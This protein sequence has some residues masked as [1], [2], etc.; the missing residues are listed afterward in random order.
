[1]AIF[2]KKKEKEKGVAGSKDGNEG[3]PILDQQGGSASGSAS[4]HN[5]PSAAPPLGSG[6]A[7]GQPSSMRGPPSNGSLS[8]HGPKSSLGQQQQGGA[9][10]GNGQQQSPQSAM[11]GFSGAGPNP[12]SGFG[13]PNS[14]GVGPPGS[15]SGFKFGGGGNPSNGPGPGSGMPMQQQQVGGG[16]IAS[17]MGNGPPPS[18]NQQQ[19][20]PR[21][22]K[23]SEDSSG[24]HAGYG[25]AGNGLPPS[26]GNGLPISGGPGGGAPSSDGLSNVG[27]G[28]SS[29]GSSSTRPRTQQ[30]VYP[31]SSRPLSLMPPRFL[32]ET[33][34]AP[35]GA[36]SPSPFP[37]YGHA[38]NSMASTN[39]EVYLFGGL[40]RESVK[41]DLY[42]INVSGVVSS[43][44]TTSPT[45]SA[46][47][48]PSNIIN[49][50]GVNAT[51]VQTT[52]EIPPPR[53]GH[54]VVLVSNV[55]ILWGGDTKVRADDRQDESLYLLNLSSREWTRVRSQASDSGAPN[56]GPVGR[57]G[58]SVSIVGSRFYVFGGQT[59][60]MFL[61]DLWSF[62]LNSL[63]GTPTWEVIRPS[64]SELPPR[65]TGHA[66]VTYK[67]KI[68][69][70]GGT[71]GQY[72]YND[73][74][75]FDVTTNSWKELSCIGYIPVPREGHAVTL[76]DDVMYIFGGR[77]VDGVFEDD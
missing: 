17:N 57:Y 44:T 25:I 6:N 74:W 42:I 51:L 23:I 5:N 46:N 9:G 37:R 26:S 36:L 4:G 56:A 75:C 62:D 30:I 55:L 39:A 11:N 63:K 70:F 54:A 7:G 71:D 35:P 15:A 61:N 66:S 41:N 38:A 50:G 3:S 73:T 33:R 16:G 40:V 27:G 31:W 2:G 8:Q 69:V 77:G 10:G 72:H 12:S 60:G 29:T 24:S 32:D 1:M 13:G 43:S 34:Q 76:V 52:G 21:S 14:A 22:R 28:G 49:N 20:N 48:P 19:P 18:N 59:E 47:S 58:H 53:V 68:F 45:T 64:T 67:D 65:R